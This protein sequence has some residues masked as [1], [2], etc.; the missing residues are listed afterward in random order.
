MIEDTKEVIRKRPCNEMTERKRFDNIY[1][2]YFLTTIIT[3][4]ISGCVGI[5]Y[6]KLILNGKNY[7]NICKYNII[8]P[9]NTRQKQTITNV[10]KHSK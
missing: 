2:S 10:N 4:F 1:F 3:L 7:K 6:F 8:V 5:F 9:S